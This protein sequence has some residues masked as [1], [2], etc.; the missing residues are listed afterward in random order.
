MGGGHQTNT[1]FR[2]SDPE[3]TI[4]NY[5]TG[6]TSRGG[7]PRSR[8]SNAT[9]T[10]PIRPLGRRLHNTARRLTHRALQRVQQHVMGQTSRAIPCGSPWLKKRSRVARIVI[11][12]CPTNRW[13]SGITE[14]PNSNPMAPWIATRALSAMAQRYREEPPHPPVISVTLRIRI[15][16]ATPTG[17]KMATGR[18]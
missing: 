5:A 11:C 6:Q 13:D 3:K 1:A 10:I 14:K 15:H 2:S 4:A 9:P 12:R 17:G 8:V 16:I 7:T 18:G